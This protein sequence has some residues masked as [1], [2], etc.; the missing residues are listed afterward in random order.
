MIHD[1]DISRKKDD[2]KG[3]DISKEGVGSPVTPLFSAVSHIQ[4]CPL[5]S[6]RVFRVLVKLRA[7]SQGQRGGLGRFEE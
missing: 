1:F 7:G 5:G 6:P 4:L 2:H 3:D